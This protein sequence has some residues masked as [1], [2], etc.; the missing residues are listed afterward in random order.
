MPRAAENLD[1]GND[2][3]GKEKDFSGLGNDFSGKAKEKIKPGERKIGLK[4]LPTCLGKDFSGKGRERNSQFFPRIQC[5]L[6]EKAQFH[7]GFSGKKAR[8]TQARA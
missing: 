8:V 3:S 7:T 6:G 1:R 5:P 4:N 2:F